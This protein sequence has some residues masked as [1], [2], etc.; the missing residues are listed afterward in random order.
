MIIKHKLIFA[1]IAFMCCLSISGMQPKALS[2]NFFV[3]DNTTRR[4][5]SIKVHSRERK[6]QS[7]L[8]EK[9]EYDEN[10][11]QS[12]EIEVLQF[13][14]CEEPE[15]H[16]ITKNSQIQPIIINKSFIKDILEKLAQSEDKMVV[17]AL[18]PSS[19]AK[20]SLANI[21]ITYDACST[22]LAAKPIPFVPQ[23]KKPKKKPQRI[24]LDEN[25]QHEPKPVASQLSQKPDRNLNQPFALPYPDFASFE[26]KHR[27]ISRREKASGFFEQLNKKSESEK[28]AEILYSSMENDNARAKKSYYSDLATHFA[29]KILEI[30]KLSDEKKDGKEFNDKQKLSKELALEIVHFY[31]NAIESNKD[32]GA[33]SFDEY[34]T[35]IKNSMRTTM[36][37]SSQDGAGQ[38]FKTLND[39]ISESGQVI[40]PHQENKKFYTKQAKN[41]NEENNY[42]FRK[43]ILGN[44]VQ[45]GGEVIKGIAVQT[46]GKLTASYMLSF[47]DD[48]NTLK[49]RDDL[50]EKISETQKELDKNSLENITKK[51][52]DIIL[53]ETRKNKLLFDS[54]N[55]NKLTQEQLL[56][57]FKDLY[58]QPN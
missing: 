31:W 47:V 27:G 58:A 6:F 54:I 19:T 37:R 10:L 50:K 13:E 34:S 15:Y 35:A 55:A 30:N 39:V 12:T 32:L 1:A 38:L 8:L 41:L 21:A 14:G 40:K 2:G 36:E 49:T 53:K 18:L 52:K 43:D 46:A 26:E 42:Q 33:P 17:F 56:Q 25:S 4:P 48:P 9:A 23:T 22:A 45:S 20:T 16:L 7:A 29:I 57:E 24:C 5:Y 44:L 3:L 11:V 28:T 51:H